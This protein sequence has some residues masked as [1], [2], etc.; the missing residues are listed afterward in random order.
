MKTTE[1]Y[2]KHTRNECEHFVL[3]N[4]NVT[5]VHRILKKLNASRSSGRDQISAKFLKDGAPVVVIHLA[6]IIN[7]SI[8]LDTFL[9]KCKIAKLKPLFK[10]GI[11][12]EAKNYRTISLLPLISKVIEK[13]IQ[14]QTQDYLQR[15]ELLYIYQSEFRANHS[16]NTCVFR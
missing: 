12:T 16:T 10:K 1:E 7:L 2:F 9:S 13:S 15:N 5:T 3:H 14:D 4:V 6:N 8:K 11:E